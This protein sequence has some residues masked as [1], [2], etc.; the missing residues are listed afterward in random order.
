MQDSTSPMKTVLAFWLL[1]D[2]DTAA[3]AAG[4]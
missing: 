3:F 4:K 1:T 2:D